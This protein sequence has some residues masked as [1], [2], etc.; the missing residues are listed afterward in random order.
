MVAYNM[1]LI[2]SG[3]LATARGT[4]RRIATK[5][6][7]IG[8][9]INLS[10]TENAPIA[11]THDQEIRSYAKELSKFRERE[12][13]IINLLEEEDRRAKSFGNAERPPPSPH[14]QPTQIDGKR[15]DTMEKGGKGKGTRNSAEKRLGGKH[16]LGKPIWLGRSPIVR[17]G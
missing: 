4:S 13:G 7:H 1:R 2:L 10:I 9:A 8:A 15:R 6:K 12:A 11:M 3:D 5:L 16:R 17:L 14:A